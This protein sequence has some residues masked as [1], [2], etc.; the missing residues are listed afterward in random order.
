MLLSVYAHTKHDPLTKALLPQV[1]WHL[2][3][4]HS[5]DTARLAFRH[6]QHFHAGKLAEVAGL[7]HDY[8]KNS[9]IFQK[10]LVDSTIIADHKSA[11]ARA[12]YA[13]YPFPAGLLLAYV[14]FGHHSGLPNHIST[15]AKAIGLEDVLKEP[16]TWVE[17]VNPSLPPLSKE[18]I[19]PMAPTLNPGLSRS[20]MIRMLHSALVDADYLDT[21]QFL[22][23]DK[24][25]KR[26]SYLPLPELY[27]PY[28]MKIEEL[29][30]RTPDSEV[31]Q[32]RREVL[33]GCLEKASGP[34]GFYTLTAPTG[35][36]KTYAALGFAFRHAKHHG[37][38]R[39]VTCLPFISL[40]EQTVSVY[41]NALGDLEGN[42]VLEHHSNITFTKEQESEFD[43]RLMAA[44]NWDAGLIVTTNVQLFESLFAAKPSKTRKLHRLANSI[45]ILDEAQT[46][47]EKLLKP[48]LAV[49]RCLCVDY[50]ATV[51]FSTATQPALKTEWLDGLQAEEII[52]NPAHM[53]TRICRVQT[54][55]LGEQSDEELTS[56]IIEQPK[57]LCIVNTRKQ[58]RLLYGR[59]ANKVGKANVFHLSGLMCAE[60]RS[61]SL[62]EISAK[63]ES[64]ECYVI[65]T[66]LIEAGVDLD[67]PVVFRQ[68]AGIEAI[69]QAAGRCNRE[70][71]LRDIR[72][73]LQKGQVFLFDS[74]DHPVRHAW[75]KERAQFSR[76]ILRSYS[77]PLAPDAIHAYFNRLYGFGKNLD[78]QGILKKLNGG[79]DEYSF[80]FREIADTF[81]WIDEEAVPVIIPWDQAARNYLLQ[82]QAALYPA[83]Y[84]RK[85]QRYTVP[86]YSG[87]MAQLRLTGR[88][89]A[90]GDTIFYLKDKEGRI[91]GEI[92][93]RYHVK[94]G[95]LVQPKE[96]D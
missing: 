87:E 4:R 10:R 56:R 23:P 11:G 76:L 3:D 21:E 12:V 34:K 81:K 38:S 64:G 95:L 96:E 32:L 78:E 26:N 25:A 66:P 40:I 73:N 7:A 57:A 93:D 91:G 30:S 22:Q 70:G 48:V 68:M 58:A 90:I 51:V 59:V 84:M 75:Y 80:Q 65:S 15:S 83:F 60:H 92:T 19:P 79:A 2:L 89:G 50:G 42:I 43:P 1:H 85:L 74:A 35:S 45:I 69:A 46:L 9:V 67:F 82:A 77:D 54:A 13:Q 24:A 86:L 71:K 47:P 14:I 18:D 31:N 49:L 41:R 44:E 63:L 17:G 20:L 72:G 5:R 6:G 94:T 29:L 55:S 16:L 62:K 8:G 39:I 88:L 61:S 37:M 33:E 27:G 53:Y 36:G 28:E 52:P